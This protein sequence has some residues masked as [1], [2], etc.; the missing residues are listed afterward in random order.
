MQMSA[1]DWPCDMQWAAAGVARFRDHCHIISHKPLFTRV[2]KV[3]SLR[4][5][6]RPRSDLPSIALVTTPSYSL[7]FPHTARR[8]P[9]PSRATMSESGLYAAYLSLGLQALTPIILGSF[10]SLKVSPPKRPAHPCTR[11]PQDSRFDHC[12][13]QKGRS[14]RE[15]GV[16]GRRGGRGGSRG[17]DARVG[18][19]A[20]LPRVWVDCTGG[21]MGV[22]QVLWQGVDQLLLGCL[23]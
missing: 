9:T 4:Y 14:G 20:L 13:T 2:V 19:F 5:I 10:K 8:S 3:L 1:T 7:G 12:E 6:A 23:L 22:A 18:G 16:D 15:Q 21:T 11:S 17:G